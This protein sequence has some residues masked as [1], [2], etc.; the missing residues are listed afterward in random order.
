[1]KSTHMILASTMFLLLTGCVTTTNG[2]P[3]DNAVYQKSYTKAIANGQSEQTARKVANDACV[4]HKLAE[5]SKSSEASA[6]KMQQQ[7]NKEM[8]KSKMN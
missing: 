4:S 5:M 8:S 7:M 2:C 6:K 3:S 1:M